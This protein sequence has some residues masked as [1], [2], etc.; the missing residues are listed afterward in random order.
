MGQEGRNMDE[1]GRGEMI[2]RRGVPA[3]HKWKRYIFLSELF[4]AL[5]SNKHTLSI[6]ICSI[7]FTSV[8]IAL[9][10]YTLLIGYHTKHLYPMIDL[11]FPCPF[12]HFFNFHFYYTKVV[13]IPSNSCSGWKSKI[14]YRPKSSL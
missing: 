11:I 7:I 12:A 6:T 14:L 13:H 8:Y 2:Q 9:A 1:E 4:V 10:V 5:V 3:S